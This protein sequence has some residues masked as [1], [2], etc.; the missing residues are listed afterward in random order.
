MILFFSLPYS[1]SQF[2]LKAFLLPVDLFWNTEV[3]RGLPI[4]QREK[5]M[6]R[7]EI[8]DVTT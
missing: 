4:L 1:F 3:G 8:A 2:S 7:I 6:C 5:V